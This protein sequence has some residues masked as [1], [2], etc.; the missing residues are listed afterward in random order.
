MSKLTIPTSHRRI[1]FQAKAENPVI[2]QARNKNFITTVGTKMVAIDA[3]VDGQEYNK[4]IIG[5]K[6]EE[7]D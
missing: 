2:K 4:T 6:G 7:Y 1:L 3:D 5:S